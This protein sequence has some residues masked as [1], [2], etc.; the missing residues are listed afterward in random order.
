MFSKKVCGER[1][2]HRNLNRAVQNQID[3]IYDQNNVQ[4]IARFS[5]ADVITVNDEQ[6]LRSDDSH[7]NTN[8]AKIFDKSGL[9]SDNS[10]NSGINYVSFSCSE[11]SNKSE[12]DILENQNLNFAEK[13]ADW[14][15]KCRLPKGHLNSLLSILREHDCFNSL[16]TDYRA[17]LKTPRHAHTKEIEGGLYC[18]FGLAEGLIDLVK[19]NPS[20]PTEIEIL[21]NIDGLPLAKSSGSQLWPILCSVSACDMETTIFPAGIYHGY[22]KL[23]NVNEFLNDFVQELKILMLNGIFVLGKRYNVKIKGIICDAPARAFVACTKN[24]SRYFG[25]GKCT[26]EGECLLSRIDIFGSN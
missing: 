1:Q 26:Q 6:S 8:I 23:C 12:D 2:R 10:S 3:D 20:L 9:D 14:A 4:S 7:E 5:N 16:P 25:C 22:T 11:H 19:N 18:H 13:I 17:L 21:I 24:H 15:V